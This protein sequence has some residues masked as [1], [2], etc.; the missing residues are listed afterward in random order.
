MFAEAFNNIKSGAVIVTI[1]VT[2]IFI[3]LA[4][5]IYKLFSERT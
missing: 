1:V 5:M 2:I 4:Y 3:F